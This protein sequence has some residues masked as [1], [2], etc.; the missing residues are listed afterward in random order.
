MIN[1]PPISSPDKP[2]DKPQAI[3][4]SPIPQEELQ[5]PPLNLLLAIF[6]KFE[7]INR[8]QDANENASLISLI[9]QLKQDDPELKQSLTINDKQYTISG[10]AVLANLQS[11]QFLIEN[12]Y[13]P[14]NHKA[15][16]LS[17]GT[18][19]TISRMAIREGKEDILKYH[20]NE[21]LKK[22]LNKFKNIDFDQDPSDQDSLFSLIDELRQEDPELKQSLTID[23]KQYTI[24]GLAVLANLRSV[25]L[26]I[27]NQIV[28]I[29]H[30]ACTLK[31]GTHETISGMAIRE[32]KEDI[33]EYHLDELR[34]N[35]F[36]HIVCF[37]E[38]SSFRALGY[39]IHNELKGIITYLLKE[40]CFDIN[41]SEELRTIE[42]FTDYGES[43]QY[44]EYKTSE[45]DVRYKPIGIAL[46]KFREDPSNQD[47]IDNIKFLIDSGVT[48]LRIIGS[49]SIEKPKKGI[50]SIESFEFI[51]FESLNLS[52][53]NEQI[54]I[55]KA[56]ITLFED[57]KKGPPKTPAPPL[58]LKKI[59]SKLVR[60]KN[61]GPFLK[62]L[63]LFISKGMRSYPFKIEQESCPAFFVRNLIVPIDLRRDIFSL[64]KNYSSPYEA[65]PISK[66][67]LKNMT[68]EI[69]QG[70]IPLILN[71]LRSDLFPS[72]VD[73][74]AISGALD[75]SSI[76]GISKSATATLKSCEMFP[77]LRPENFLDEEKWPKFPKLP[78][79][80]RLSILL[81]DK[82]MADQFFSLRVNKK[83]PREEGK[84]I[85]QL[86]DE[87]YNTPAEIR[88]RLNINK[89][90]I[91][92]TFDHTEQVRE[93]DS[94]IAR[95]LAENEKLR[96]ENEKLKDALESSATE[97][98]GP[99][100][101]Q[102][103]SSTSHKRKQGGSPDGEALAGSQKISRTGD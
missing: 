80:S 54:K 45:A 85:E 58:P 4:T 29:E 47:K 98:K 88:E 26:L 81:A 64:A 17:D 44:S 91:C 84:L 72:E 32:G 86:R 48:N 23:D 9:E 53:F 1:P 94:E 77:Y 27:Y 65:E 7:N 90:T 67:S 21:K 75:S 59:D 33:L 71:K 19:E 12:K 68:K 66:D 78:I 74:D 69:F 93:K 38:R 5:Q 51:V 13:V 96:S 89:E 56:A 60:L 3:V 83:L 30:E 99:E 50:E 28:P 97:K 10:L 40:Q 6:N 87:Y 15:Q 22:I 76:I 55:Q 102:S 43:Y 14:L 36:D 100:E 63:E 20:L 24:S 52:I 35:K 46:C 62:L 8:D 42:E 70:S 49:K 11:V 16:T 103:P 31:D 2:Q 73:P 34:T 101:K 95:L 37:N 25:K 92:E 18:H 61:K 41:R 82:K 79:L 39:A 57:Y